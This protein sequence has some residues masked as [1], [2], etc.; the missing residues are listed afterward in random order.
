MSSMSGLSGS[1]AAAGLAK[2]KGAPAACASVSDAARSASGTAGVAR[3]M[4][5]ANA[6]RLSSASRSASASTLTTV[7]RSGGL[8]SAS[9]VATLAAPSALPKMKTRGGETNRPLAPRAASYEGGAQYPA[10]GVEE[11]KSPQSVTT[12]GTRGCSSDASGEQPT[13]STARTTS[14]PLTTRPKTTCLPSSCGHGEKV[15]KYCD[16]FECFPEFPMLSA[17]AR[18]CFSRRPCSSSLNFFPKTEAPPDPLPL[19]ISPPCMTKPG[20]L[21]C[22]GEPL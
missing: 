19:T 11:S 14:R 16:E 9:E 15:M 5:C 21:R 3:T 2:T 12:T 17:P 20:L 10:G 7:A 6:G 18:S 22:T 13:A 8:A 1:T 4:P